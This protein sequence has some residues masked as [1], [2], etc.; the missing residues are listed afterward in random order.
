MVALTLNVPTT[1]YTN[2]QEKREESVYRFFQLRKFKCRHTRHFFKSG[3]E[4]FRFA[5]LVATFMLLFL[6]GHSYRD[7]SKTN[8]IISFTLLFR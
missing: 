8:D 5:C 3:F 2:S 7:V 1:K 6:V 4:E